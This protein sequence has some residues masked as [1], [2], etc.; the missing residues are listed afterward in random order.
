VS[1]VVAQFAAVAQFEP[2][3][4]QAGRAG[5]VDD[6]VTANGLNSQLKLTPPRPKIQVTARLGGGSV[7]RLVRLSD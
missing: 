6:V 2:P 4:K 5:H 7:S 3:S 1:A